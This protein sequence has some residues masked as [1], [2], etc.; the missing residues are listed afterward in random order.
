MSSR[1]GSTR[2][3]AEREAEMT[4]TLVDRQPTDYQ[5]LAKRVRSHPFVDGPTR[6][7]VRSWDPT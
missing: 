7:L 4:K 3:D 6:K 5:E 1:A 2:A